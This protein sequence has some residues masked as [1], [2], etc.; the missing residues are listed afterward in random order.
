[1]CGRTDC[2]LL[3]GSCLTNFWLISRFERRPLPGKPI[4]QRLVVDLLSDASVLCTF[5]AGVYCTGMHLPRAA[6][7]RREAAPAVVSR[8]PI[9]HTRVLVP[10]GRRAELVGDTIRAQP[11]GVGTAQ[12]VRVQRGMPGARAGALQRLTELGP[13][14]KEACVAARACSSAN[15]QLAL[16]FATI[17][18]LRQ[19]VAR[20]EPRTWTKRRSGETSFAQSALGGRSF[21]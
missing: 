17:G 1:M 9:E 3:F 15:Q 4:S 2:S 21:S 18:T 7:K 8:R 14:Q 16:Q 20:F 19:R 13:R 6:S 5:S 12:I 10:H 11:G